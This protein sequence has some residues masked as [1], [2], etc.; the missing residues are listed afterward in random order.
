MPSL[1]EAEVIDYRAVMLPIEG[2][3]PID[4]QRIKQFLKTFL[5][6]QVN[7]ALLLFTR[8]DDHH[9]QAAYYKTNQAREIGLKRLKSC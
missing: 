6:Q 4:L 8:G 1:D 2:I 5:Q 9:K 3:E 7:E